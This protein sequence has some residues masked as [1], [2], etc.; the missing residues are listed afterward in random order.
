M[1]HRSRTT[2]MV[3][4][5]MSFAIWITATPTFTEFEVKCETGVISVHYIILSLLLLQSSI[6]SSI[7]RGTYL[8]VGAVLND[9]VALTKGFKVSEKAVCSAGINADSCRVLRGDV[10]R[11]FLEHILKR[12]RGKRDCGDEGAGDRLTS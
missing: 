3:R 11:T 7:G 4:T 8:T 1:T 5:P 10:R 2:L 6:L 12:K 9:G